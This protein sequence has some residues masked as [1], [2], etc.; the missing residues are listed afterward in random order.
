MTCCSHCGSEN[1]Q[2]F[3]RVK[4]GH[5]YKC[6]SCGRTFRATNNTPFYRTQKDLA[7][8]NHYLDLMFD[9]PMSVRKIAAKVGIYYK[10]AF[11]WR[12][13]GLNALKKIE[14]ERL[15]GIV[16]ADETY[17]ALS[18]KGKKTG[19]P[20]RPRKR[21][22]VHVSGISKQQVYV[23]TAMDR[24]KNM[25]LQSTCLARPTVKQEIDVLG[26]H[27]ATDAVLVTDMHNAYVGLAKHLGATHETVQRS[28]DRRG[29]YHVQSINSLHKQMKRFM[30]PFNGV[31]TKY[32]DNYM[33][34]YQW[35]TGTNDAVSGLMQRTGS[36]TCSELT[37][38]Q[39]TLK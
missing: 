20:R 23:L 3:G 29:S 26:P 37:A 30:H 12:H 34:F 13:K 9:A 14:G 21:G 39:M 5:R 18:Y 28:T 17:F 16:E 7:V 36:V 27:I 15:T 19:M 33:A 25:L 1:F 2:K 4:N 35:S 6:K 10:T 24:T 32:L 31:A 38:M 8:W 22:G 11:Y